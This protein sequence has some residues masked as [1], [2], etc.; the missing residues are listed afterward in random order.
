M[1][2]IKWPE[3][4]KIHNYR[5]VKTCASCNNYDCGPG[6]DTCYE[7]G[8]TPRMNCICNLWKLRGSYIEDSEDLTAK[9]QDEEAKR[10]KES[11]TNS[12]TTT[13]V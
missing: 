12:Q 13:E 2:K 3:F 1:S 11:F 9:Q 10:I 8:L 7:R 5:E 4:D 6:F